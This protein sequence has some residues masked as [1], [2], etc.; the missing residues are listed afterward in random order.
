M[1]TLLRPFTLVAASLLAFGLPSCGHRSG[2]PESPRPVPTGGLHFV[3]VATGLDQPL[4]LTSPPR[5]ARL[6]VLERTGKIKL[7]KNGVV[8]ARPFLD[9]TALITSAGGEQ[10]L[11]GMAFAP[12]YASSGR[13][14]VDYTDV[15]GDTRVARYRVSSD[16]DSADP[17]SA[18]IVLAV[19]QPYANHNGGM[20]AF[21]PDGMLYVGLGDGGSAGDPQGN[22][23][24]RG[25]LLAKILRLD[26]RGAGPYTIPAGNP[27]SSPNRPEIWC[28]GLRNP[29]RFSFDR[30]N[31][32]LYIADV[33]QNL[34]EEVDVATAASGG[35]RGLN[36]GWNIMEGLYCYSPPAGC[37][38]TGLTMPVLDY[39]HRDGCAIIGGFVYRGTAAP[40]LAG[41]YFYADY[42][43]KFLRSFRWSNGQATDQK[44]WGSLPDQ[45]L[46]FGEDA[47]GEVY[48][49]LQ[50]G[51]VIRLAS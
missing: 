16:P 24:N 47:N 25:V 45:P 2:G 31:G 30:Q 19:A 33:G 14:Y 20:L 6:F 15:I 43:S 41:Q 12:D 10:G 7:V 5:D 48:V 42:C 51:T 8:Q 29:W 32:D 37:D 49:L 3:T 9:V 34:H 23:Q 35:G 39:S 44:D 4:F 17:A 26:V 21:G 50:G 13:F 22:G 36:Y 40:A 18:E 27:F 11:L 38:T 1:S 28:Y 46:S